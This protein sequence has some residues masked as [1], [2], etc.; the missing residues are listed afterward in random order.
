MIR[1]SIVICCACAS[2]SRALCSA[3]K[4]TRVCIE[5]FHSPVSRSPLSVWYATNSSRTVSSSMPSIC[6]ISSQ[7]RGVVMALTS[8]NVCSVA[9]CS[10]VIWASGANLP[11]P[12]PF[13]MPSDAHARMSASSVS[14]KLLSVPPRQTTS[15]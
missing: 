6:A 1:L 8:V 11:F 9:A 5:T 10:R 13:T 2:S 12:T 15:C 14:V 4:L 3:R 7:P